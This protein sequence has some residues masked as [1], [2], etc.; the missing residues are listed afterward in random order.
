VLS[1][2]AKPFFGRDACLKLREQGGDRF[3]CVEL[4]LLPF[5]AADLD[6]S[7]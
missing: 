7:E 6:E 3:E 4:V 5:A 1:Q 2:I